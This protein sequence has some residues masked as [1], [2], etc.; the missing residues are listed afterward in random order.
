MGARTESKV[1]KSLSLVILSILYGLLPFLILIDLIP[2]SQK[3]VALT[4]G[5]V[6][7]YLLLRIFGVP[8][9]ELGITLNRWRESLIA[10]VPI[11]LGF[12]VISVI[13]LLTQGSRYNPDETWAFYVFYVF[14][15]CPMQEFL[16]RGAL[17]RIL[18][19]FHLHVGWETIIASILFAYVHIIYKDP[20]TLTAMFI[21]GLFWYRIYLKVPNLLGVTLSHIILGV[22]TISLGLV[23]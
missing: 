15:S 9:S 2:W 3:F 16:F 23:N 13:F 8:N 6:I 1:T 14:V 7:L 11:T 21:V 5:G 22:L 18:A 20:L 10:A 17:H 19:P 4:A 12:L